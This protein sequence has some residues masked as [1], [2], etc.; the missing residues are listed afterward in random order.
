MRDLGEHQLSGEDLKQY[1]PIVPKTIRGTIFMLHPLRYLPPA[2]DF[3][4][5]P[6]LDTIWPEA[7]TNRERYCFHCFAF[8][9][10]CEFWHCKNTCGCCAKRHPALVSTNIQVP[11]YRICTDQFV[12]VLPQSLQHLGFMG[13]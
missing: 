12:G 10:K 11:P 9:G 5:L 1:Y 8:D 4:F 7:S 13:E 3:F 6:Y 2:E